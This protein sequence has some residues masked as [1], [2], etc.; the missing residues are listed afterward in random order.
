MI[1]E[2]LD[3]CKALEQPLTIADVGTGSGVIA[4]TI[5]KH[6]PG[7]RV[8]ATD[9]SEQ[10]IAVAR[11][12]AE[13][14]G[15]DAQ[16]EF[17]CCDLF[18]DSLAAN[19]FDLILSNPPYISEEEYQQLEPTVKD[20]EPRGALVGGQEGFELI[21]QLT[22][23]AHPLLKDSGQ[24][25]F[26]FSPMLEAKLEHFIGEAWESPRVVKDL[27]GLARIVCLEKAA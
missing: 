7:S 23:V 21:A 22:Q 6:I 15:V 19:L 18:P 17:H 25:M 11:R 4:I 13:K 14:H 3:A 24:L 26:E 1:V 2:A 27:A 9:I 20:Y 12:N 10:A 5:A 8:I 16:I